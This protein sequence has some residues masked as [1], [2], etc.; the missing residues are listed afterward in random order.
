MTHERPDMSTLSAR[1][2]AVEKRLSDELEAKYTPIRSPIYLSGERDPSAPQHD[3]HDALGRGEKVLMGPDPRIPC[4]PATP[5]L[6]DFFRLRFGN[7]MHMMQSARLALKNGHGEKVPL[8]CLLHDISVTGFICGDHGYW[9][10]Q[11][12][13]PYVDPEIAW[14]IAAHQVLRFFPDPDVGYEFPPAYIK[15]FGEEFVPEPYV[16]KAYER[17]RDHQWYMT[18]RL[19]LFHCRLSHPG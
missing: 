1:A 9:G 15:Y 8:A 18:A 12:V 19:E 6:V 17:A 10:A 13:A 7:T 16:R 14:A 2:D 11:L 3:F 4:M 5:S